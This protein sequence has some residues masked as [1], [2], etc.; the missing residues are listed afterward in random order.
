MIQKITYDER[1]ANVEKKSFIQSVEEG[2]VT[3]YNFNT[4]SDEAVRQAGH[5][6][7]WHHL[8][9]EDIIDDSRHLPKI[10][11]FEDYIFCSLRSMHIEGDT[12]EEEHISFILGKNYLISFQERPGDVFDDVRERILTNKGRL[13]KRGVDYL[14]YRLLDAVNDELGEIVTF[15]EDKIQ[16]IEDLLIKEGHHYD[17]VEDILN[18]KKQLIKIRK[19]VFPIEEVV[20]K[21]AREESDIITTITRQYFKDIHERLLQ[22][23]EQ[24]KDFR[25]LAN[26]LMDLHHLNLS[27]R[28]NSVMQLLTIVS[29]VFI[30]LTFITGVY[31]MNFDSMP[32]LHWQYGYVGV[33]ILMVIITIIMIWLTKRRNWL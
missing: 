26:N 8:L 21:L 30:P 19:I 17:A 1:A 6:F 3:W 25:E 14:L 23:L 12:V 13:R 2:K 27:Q 20:R 15:F 11:A 9:I 28:T 22:I 10:D 29:T 16:D 31:G 4:T 5:F 7:G 18:L 32:E 33:W 24:F